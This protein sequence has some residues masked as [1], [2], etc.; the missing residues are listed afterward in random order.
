MKSTTPAGEN[1]PEVWLCRRKQQGSCYMG[2]E[3][4]DTCYEEADL[5]NY[6]SGI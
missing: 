1:E 5:A 4:G 2:G 3:R 6:E